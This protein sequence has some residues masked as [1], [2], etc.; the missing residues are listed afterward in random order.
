[1]RDRHAWAVALA[2]AA[3]LAGCGPPPAVVPSGEGQD[4]ARSS[5]PESDPEPAPD[6]ATATCRLVVRVEGLK[7]ADG[8]VRIA[9]FRAPDG[10][11]AGHE[12]AAATRVV[13]AAADGVEA[14]FEDLP[15]GPAAV[16]AI[17]DR[18]ENGALDTNWM[19]IPREGSGASNNPESSFGPPG[20][21]QALFD[22]SPPGQTITIRLRHFD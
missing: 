6:P 7:D 12:K 3:V 21:D 13:P 16:S 8:V 20:Y 9:V 2:G 4:A 1:M 17:H 18:N 5:A 11:P 15:P 10:F 19:G 14:I 22:L